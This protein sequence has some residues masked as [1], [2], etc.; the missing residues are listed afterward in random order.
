MMKSIIAT[1]LIAEVALVAGFPDIA[2]KVAE[3]RA[4]EQRQ[5]GFLPSLVPFPEFP[6]TPNHAVFN[7]FDPKSQLVSTSG[8]HAWQAPGPGDI[9]GPCAGLNAAANHGY[10]PRDGIATA[11]S[12]NTGLWEAYGLDKTA[13]LFLQTATMFFDGDP[14]SGRW[15]IGPH[16]DKTASLG[17]LSDVLGNQTGICAYGHLKTEADASITRGDWLDPNP[18]FNGN[19]ASH[20]K[21][22]QELFDLA[23]KR[24]NGFI[25]P[26]V[27]AEHSYNRKQY[28]IQNN[29]NYFAPVYA[30]VAFTFGAHMFA[31][32]LLGNHS[33]EEPRGFLTKEVFMDFF[34]YKKDAAG[35]LKYTYGHE[36]IPDNWYKRHAL[37]A[38]TLTDIVVS[39]AQQC[40]SYPSNCQV[41]GNTGTV[42]SFSGVDPGD[43]TGGLI[44]SF[45]NLS[46]PDKLGCF[47]LQNLQA[48]IPSFL[49]NVLDPASLSLVNG[50]IP[51]VLMPA[52]KGLDISGTCGNLPPGRT[53]PG[54]GGV[55]PG[56]KDMNVF[57][58]PRA[59]Y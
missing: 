36:R 6:G 37:D 14:I 13:T 23:D 21:F 55:Y 39:T 43:L 51:T 57:E 16:S 53:T 45:E 52:L 8:D 33:A 48:E 59:A 41:G 42:N 5:G 31:F 38:W 2:R 24:A 3:Q 20:P 12:V 47:I 19:C 26:Q 29:P 32:E 25:T 54:Y 44:N 1:S 50:L 28:S 15:S 34:S 10:L 7:T 4:L 46:N 58:G 11:Q 49:S 35:N 27:M 18:E 9:R 17:P 40:A 30:G 22:M 56:A